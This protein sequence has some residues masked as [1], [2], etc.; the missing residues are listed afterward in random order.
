MERLVYPQFVSSSSVSKKKGN[1]YQTPKKKSR[2][3]VKTK[4]KAK[5]PYSL[6]HV[7]SSFIQIVGIL[8]EIC[9]YCLR[10]LKQKRQACTFLI[11]ASL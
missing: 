4:E 8:F 10:L 9:K 1:F 11:N 6:H 5:D 3:R 2:L 7:L